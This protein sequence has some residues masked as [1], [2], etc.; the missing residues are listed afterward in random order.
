MT[1]KLANPIDER[2]K[3][4]EGWKLGRGEDYGILGMYLSDGHDEDH[5][6]DF[7]AKVVKNW[8]KRVTSRWDRASPVYRY[9]VARFWI[10]R[11]TSFNSQRLNQFHDLIKRLHR[12]EDCQAR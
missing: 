6:W 7:F 5:E 9:H 1:L 8:I 2:V 10:E 3:L 11:L 12:T 4:P